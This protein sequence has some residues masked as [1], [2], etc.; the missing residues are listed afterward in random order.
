MKRNKEDAIMLVEKINQFLTALVDAMNDE[1]QA[2]IDPGLNKD[3]TSF[4][5]C[6]PILD[7]ATDFIHHCRSSETLNESYSKWRRSTH[8]SSCS[9]Y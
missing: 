1:M 9:I 5:E 6:V 7:D 3:L 8:A 2:D 4:T